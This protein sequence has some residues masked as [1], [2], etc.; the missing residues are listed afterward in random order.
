MPISYKKVNNLKVSEDLLYFV[1]NE[2]LKD[3][4]ISP[5]RF[6]LNFDK[7]AHE[8]AS[9]NRKLIQIRE[10]LQKKLMLGISKIEIVESKLQNIK[11]F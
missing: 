1:N 8:L 9:Q 10:N 4:N 2:L 5:D 7:I 6:W 11:N 3:I